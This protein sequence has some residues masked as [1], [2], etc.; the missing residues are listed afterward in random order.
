MHAPLLHVM[1]CQQ[2]SQSQ[3]LQGVKSNVVQHV[4]L[5]SS[6]AT[7]CSPDVLT[8]ILLSTQDPPFTHHPCQTYVAGG[9]QVYMHSTHQRTKRLR[10]MRAS[11]L[12][13]RSTSQAGPCLQNL[14]NQL[15]FQTA[16]CSSRLWA[17]AS[18]CMLGIMPR[19]VAMTWNIQMTLPCSARRQV[20][21][22]QPSELVLFSW[23]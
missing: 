19:K 9:K 11:R 5:C 2:V 13:M 4:M 7:G 23:P 16:R 3:M 22:S 20:S 12:T 15:P 6:A 8:L 10:K 1:A 21:V 14:T 17:K 18:L